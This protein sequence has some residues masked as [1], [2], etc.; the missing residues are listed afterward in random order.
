MPTDGQ[1]VRVLAVCGDAGGASAIAPVV[2]K[3]RERPDMCIELWAYG[4]GVEIIRSRLIEPR[5]IP[6]DADDMMLQAIWRQFNPDVLLA[7][8]S[9]NEF[10]FERKFTK[11]ARS[12]RVP[13]LVVMDACSNSD[14][15]FGPSKGV[16]DALPDLIAVPDSRSMAECIAAGIPKEKLV[17]T[18]QPA[19]DDLACR[20]A[21]FSLEK[22]AVIRAN[23]DVRP[24]EWM[25]IFLSQ[26][27]RQLTLSDNARLA[28][29]GYDQY[30]VFSRLMNLLEREASARNR[31][32]VLVVRPHPRE[33]NPPA[34][35]SGQT[36]RYLCDR[37]HNPYE[38]MMASDLVIGMSSIAL[39][40]ACY[41]GCP[42]LSLQPGAIYPEEVASNIAGVSASVRLWSEFDEKTT[43]MMFDDHYRSVYMQRLKAFTVD[44]K[45]ADRVVSLILRMSG[46]RSA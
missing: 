30:E 19:F 24:D 43:R 44:G 39:V 15:R 38:I 37:Q 16:F 22:R 45:A 41:L 36:V 33:D 26:P 35:Q 5:V 42:T 18:G 29:P 25:A 9:V 11:V 6:L 27:L 40:E 21:V 32:G 31:P 2:R 10:E 34:G 13:S 28:F 1:R 17:V 20:K 14:R 46:R 12:C 3:T 7:A 4:P 8:S 23:M